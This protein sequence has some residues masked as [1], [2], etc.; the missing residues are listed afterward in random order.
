[1]VLLSGSYCIS[2]SNDTPEGIAVVQGNRALHAGGQ[3]VMEGQVE[4]RRRR[5]RPRRRWMDDV[6]EWMEMG[7]EEA[8]RLA[9]DRKTYR[10]HVGNATSRPGYAS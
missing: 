10:R 3:M 9:A 4:G 2:E 8:V 6:V 7:A 5:G 1:M